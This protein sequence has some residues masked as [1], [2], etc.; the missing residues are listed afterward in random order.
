MSIADPPQYWWCLEHQTVE[1]RDGCANTVRLGPFDEYADAANAIE[2][3]QKRS[4]EWDADEAWNDDP[5][6]SD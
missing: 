4:E 3:A 5:A 1:T 2:L 6:S